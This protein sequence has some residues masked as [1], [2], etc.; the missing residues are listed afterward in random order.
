MIGNTYD[1][2]EQSLKA[3]VPAIEI[4][5]GTDGEASKEVKRRPRLSIVRFVL[6]SPLE[7]L[8]RLIR[9]VPGAWRLL[10]VI[11]TP[12]PKLN[13]KIIHFVEVRSQDNGDYRAEYP[14]LSK[15]RCV[16]TDKQ[17]QSLLHFRDT[18]FGS[19]G[20]FSEEAKT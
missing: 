3:D 13:R 17:Q 19:E 5:A 15:A 10:L 1:Q 2:S 4:I 9:T 7:Y 16:L 6:R 11:T 20:I 18:T 14:Q 12:L 8:L